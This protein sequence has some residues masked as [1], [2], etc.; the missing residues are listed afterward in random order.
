MK[1]AKEAGT[2]VPAASEELASLQKIQRNAQFYW[3]FV[4]VRKQ[5]GARNAPR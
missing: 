4:M 1:A 2:E 3:D 5:R